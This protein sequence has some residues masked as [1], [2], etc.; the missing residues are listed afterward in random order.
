MT[1]HTTLADSFPNLMKGGQ[2]DLFQRRASEWLI[3]RAG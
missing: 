3:A 2:S 1:T